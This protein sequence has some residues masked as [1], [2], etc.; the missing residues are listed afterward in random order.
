M[1]V[2]SYL[3]AQPQKVDAEPCIAGLASLASCTAPAYLTNQLGNECLVHVA[4]RSVEQ[5]AWLCMFVARAANAQ[6]DDLI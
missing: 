5:V 6:A 4:M 1:W 2:L 3:L